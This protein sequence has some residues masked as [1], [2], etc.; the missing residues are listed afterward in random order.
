MHQADDTTFDHV[1]LTNWETVPETGITNE[2][3]I[4]S[5]AS[6][7]E[8]VILDDDQNVEEVESITIG[9]VTLTARKDDVEMKEPEEKTEEKPG[10]E[11]EE[12]EE[13]KQAGRPAE[14]LM[15][16]TKKK[17]QPVPER[18]L[19]VKKID[20]AD[21]RLARAVEQAEDRVWLDPTDLSFRFPYKNV[22]NHGRLLQISKKLSYFLRGHPLEYGLPCPNFN[23][24][25][26]SVNWEDLMDHMKQKVWGLEDWEVLQ[27]VRSS[28]T[29]RF[30]VQ[31]ARPEGPEAT[32]KGLPWKPVACRT[33][34]GHNRALMDKASIGQMV[35][36]LYTLDPEFTPAHLDLDS[37]Q[38][39]RFNF[40]PKQANM[41]EKFPRVVYHS[42]DLSHVD[43]IIRQGLIPGGWPKSS[44]RYHNYFITMPPWDANSRKLAGTRAGKPMYVAFDVE[45][46]MQLGRRIFKTDE[47]IL[48][49]DWISNECIIAV[50]D[51]HQRDFYHFNRAYAAYRKEYNSKTSSQDPNAALYEDSQLT[52]INQLGDKMFESFC[53][54]VGR[55]NLKSFPNKGINVKGVFRDSESKEGVQSKEVEGY[56]RAPFMGVSHVPQ[57]RNKASRKGWS[58]GKAKR[59]YEIRRSECI[60][61]PLLTVAE[62][63]CP[64]CDQKT[65]DG[66]H[67]C[68]RCKAVL[69][70]PTDLHLASEVARLESFARES[71]GTFALDQVTSTQPRSQR[72]RSSKSSSTSSG[73]PRRGGR[74]NFGVMRDSALNYMKKARKS[75]YQNLQDRLENDPFFLFDCSNNQLTPPCLKFIERLASSISPDFWRSSTARTAGKGTEIKTRLIFIPLPN[76]QFDLAIDVTYE[77]QV[78]HH[79]RFFSL[80]QFAV[81]SDTILNARGE[82]SPVIHG[83]N[84]MSMIVDLTPDLNLADLTNFA[85]DQW[86]FAFE[87]NGSK[88][89]NKDEAVATIEKDLPK[90]FSTIMTDTLEKAKHREFDPKGT[91]YLKLKSTGRSGWEGYTG[92][93]K[94]KGSPKS[95][96]GKQTK[97]KGH[98]GWTQPY[99]YQQDQ[100]Y[101]NER[102]Q[103]W[104]RSYPGGHAGKGSSSSSS[105]SKGKSS[106]GKQ[107]RPWEEAVEYQGAMYTKMTYRD[108]RVE[109]L[110]W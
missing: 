23:F 81:Y 100:Y 78:A 54:N 48:S 47:A 35:K 7:H 77:S 66:H 29:R 83:W 93:S 106:K 45:L 38:W 58:K 71:Y 31:V 53:Q 108:G 72:T 34:Q 26:L 63:E 42:C 39:P 50:Y 109:W 70:P 79:G 52:Q 1:D 3:D 11:K 30:Q 17:S 28:D 80:S 24:L 75:N 33:F 110:A 67:K 25:D 56:R 103:Q 94:G 85:K 92:I 86:S 98:G 89:T 46:M 60:V 82:P 107:E 16:T 43:D 95:S 99:G 49:P 9:S 13:E 88:F 96:Y 40:N 15:A 104:Q 90:A 91:E 6:T 32:W 101:W 10:E 68:R 59:D 4:I 76:R 27:V 20:H 102:H 12:K 57:L 22:N 19:E 18:P 62:I 87:Q 2:F 69:E 5:M 84:D 97:G 74:S 36:E 64:K 51:S 8:T 21:E 65:L 55:G 37:P 44:G 14:V 105:S 41:Y 61:A 73:D